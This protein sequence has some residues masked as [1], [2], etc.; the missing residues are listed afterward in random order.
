LRYLGRLPQ[1]TGTPTSQ[2]REIRTYK[3]YIV[4][5]S[6][7]YNHHIQIFDLKKLLDIDYKKGPVTFDPAKDL[8]GFYGNLPDGRAHNVLTNDASGFAY[9]VGARPRTD[10]CR[11][12]LIFLD[13]SDPSNPTSP[14]C[15]AADGYV[16]DAQCLIYKGPHTKYLGKEIC[17]AYNEDS[18]TICM[19]LSLRTPN[20]STNS[21]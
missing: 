6:E 5:G 15:A 14:G 8:T 13:L 17:Y 18:L 7:T 9:V 19:S 1:T 2:W 3:H 16:H 11:S 10:A 20:Y 12:G 21:P 4:I